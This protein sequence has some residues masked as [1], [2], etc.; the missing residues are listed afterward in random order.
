M[1][2]SAETPQPEGGER[3]E[4][5]PV[6]SGDKGAGASVGGARGACGA[7][8]VWGI[9]GAC[10]PSGASGAGGACGA[11]DACGAR[12]SRGDSGASGAARGAALERKQHRCFSRVR[13]RHEL[14]GDCPPL[15]SQN[16]I[17]P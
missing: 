17:S 14:G 4:K 11:Y 13:D 6:V 15:S 12:D 1:R 7:C 9:S 10:A 8:G 5:T 2:I 16:A 3:A